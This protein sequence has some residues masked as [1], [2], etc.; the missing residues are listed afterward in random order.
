M[1]KIYKTLKNFCKVIILKLKYK[2]RIKLKSI[3]NSHIL[4]KIY[5]SSKQGS[6]CIGKNFRSERFSSVESYGDGRIDIGENVY[7][8]TNVKIACM[9]KISIGSNTI[10]GPNVCIYDHDHDFRSND[11]NVNF[12]SEETIIGSD[13]WIGANVII[14]K[15][16]KIGNGCVISAGSVITKDVDEKT[17][18]IQKRENCL[19][20]I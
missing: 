16:V 2:C 18:V 14:V 10:I 9:E 1:T 19:I 11:K 15:G 20:K 8:N 4:P 17:C 12:L 7:L 5:I 3:S 6:I 13:V